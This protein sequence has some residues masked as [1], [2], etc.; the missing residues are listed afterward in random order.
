MHY[1][2]SFYEWINKNFVW[3]NS[4]LSSNHLH[5]M[6]WSGVITWVCTLDFVLELQRRGSDFTETGIENF[7]QL[8]DEDCHA[9]TVRKHSLFQLRIVIACLQLEMNLKC[10]LNKN[11][12]FILTYLVQSGLWQFLTTCMKIWIQILHYIANMHYPTSTSHMMRNNTCIHFCC[13]AASTTKMSHKIMLP[14]SS[15]TILARSMDASW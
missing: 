13:L 12:S 11:Q 9:L 14:L 15:I 8:F 7:Q 4:W 6:Y 5:Y 10:Y 2:Q 1:M 3:F